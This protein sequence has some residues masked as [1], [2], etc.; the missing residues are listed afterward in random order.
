MTRI[1]KALIAV[2]LL[3]WL[4]AL[5]LLMIGTFGWFGQTP[6]PLAGV[7]LV[8]LGMPWNLLLG[9]MPEAALPLV[10]V[11]APGINLLLL[12]LVCRFLSRRPR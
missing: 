3:A 5:L 2:F 12:W 1:C 6:D 4:A 11:F 7:F 8:P 10:G 9:G